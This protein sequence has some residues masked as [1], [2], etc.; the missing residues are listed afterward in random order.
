MDNTC[1]LKQ[2]GKAGAKNHIVLL[3]ALPLLCYQPYHLLSA[4]AY[5]A[6]LR[7]QDFHKTVINLILNG[8]LL[9]LMPTGNVVSH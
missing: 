9:S 8:T 3:F 2:Q 5:R 1:L 6:P 4:R 7:Q